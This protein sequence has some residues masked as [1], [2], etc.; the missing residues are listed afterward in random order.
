MFRAD[1]SSSAGSLLTIILCTVTATLNKK[2]AR[3]S[4]QHS[5]AGTANPGLS[6]VARPVNKA[7]AEG[8]DV[9]RLGSREPSAKAWNAQA[10]KYVP[11][12]HIDM[13]R[14]KPR[15]F[16]RRLSSAPIDRC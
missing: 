7:P 6:A 5:G 3:R 11:D 9:R 13:L 4:G 1:D 12:L 10:V 2:G 8:R 14:L 15:T 16:H